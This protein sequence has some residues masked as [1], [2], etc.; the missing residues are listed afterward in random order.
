IEQ[1]GISAED[2]ISLCKML[3][4][5]GVDLIDVSSGETFETSKPLYGRMY[6][7]PF[8]DKIRN[9]VGVK[10]MAVGNIY[11]ADHVNSILM[12]GRADLV[13]IGRPHLSDPY[14]TNHIAA[15][16]GDRQQNWPKPYE[17]GKQQYWQLLD[18]SS[19]KEKAT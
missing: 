3:K 5:A 4:Q 7:T 15:E 8:S 19:Q 6:Q 17:H 2:I 9:E 1:G 12:A 14:W 18:K 13:A 10:T 11:E 16:N